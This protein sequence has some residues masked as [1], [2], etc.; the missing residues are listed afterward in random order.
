M[1]HSEKY[2][3]SMSKKYPYTV[4]AAELTSLIK[5]VHETGTV[6]DIYIAGDIEQRANIRE[7]SDK[8]FNHM[9]QIATIFRVGYILGQ[10]A[11]RARET[12]HF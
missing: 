4:T 11:E 7:E 6:E 9:V 5:T 10:R 3:V 1:D 8:L 2:T 12:V